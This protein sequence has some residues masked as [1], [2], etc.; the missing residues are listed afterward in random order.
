MKD[1]FSVRV[2]NLPPGSQATITLTYA[3]QVGQPAERE[4]GRMGSSSRVSRMPTASSL[5]GPWY[6]HYPRPPHSLLRLRPCPLPAWLPDPSTPLSLLGRCPRRWTPRTPRPLSSACSSPRPWPPGTGQQA[7]L[8]GTP[9]CLP[10][11]RAAATH[12]LPSAP[13]HSLSFLLFL[14]RAAS[15]SC[16]AAACHPL[17]LSIRRS[18]PMDGS[19][20]P[21]PPGVGLVQWARRKLGGKKEGEEEDLPHNL[22]QIRG[23]ITSSTR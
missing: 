5:Y 3:T 19:E 4:R 17:L 21:A 20:L 14:L 16:Y 1:V 15:S 9:P 2:G 18:G 10:S 23:S 22:L 13:T 11:L 6:Y 7:H 12:D 8:P